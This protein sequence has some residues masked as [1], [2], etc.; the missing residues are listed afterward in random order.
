MSGA[1]AA[2]QDGCGLLTHLW[3]PGHPSDGKSSPLPC[4]YFKSNELL[5]TFRHHVAPGCRKM[6]FWVFFNQHFLL[7]SPGSV[8]SPIKKRK[9]F[10]F[11]L[12][13]CIKQA[14][15][16]R[17]VDKQNRKQNVEFTAPFT[18]VFHHVAMFLATSMFN[19]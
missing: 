17:T 5:S 13:I 7:V 11:V 2:A 12:D 4:L 15:A 16:L 6:L 18:V 1:I 3:S 19:G 14:E 8:S 9:C 10:T